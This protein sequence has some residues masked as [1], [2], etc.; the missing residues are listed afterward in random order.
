ME[1]KLNYNESTEYG[2]RLGCACCVIRNAFDREGKEWFT[3][4]L[5]ENM[6]LDPLVGFVELN[7]KAIA[8]KVLNKSDKEQVAYYVGNIPDAWVGSITDKTGLRA[9]FYIGIYSGTTMTMREVADY[10][11]VSPS[12]V[13]KLCAQGKIK[14]IGAGNKPVALRPSVVEYAK[15][16][17]ITK[18]SEN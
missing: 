4:A 10:L 2:Y 18:N 11:G 8:E 17:K 15:E 6:Y 5:N 1:K 12:M 3:D 16:R 13:T 14:S 7:K 9:G